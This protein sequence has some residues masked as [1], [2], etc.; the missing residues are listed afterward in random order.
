MRLTFLGTGAALPSRTRN[1][2]ALALSFE[3]RGGWWLFDCG[4]GTQHRILASPLSPARLERV[5]LSHLHGDHCFGLPGLLCSR[6]MHGQA[7]PIAIHGPRGTGDYLAAIERTTLTHFGFRIELG[8]VDPP[9]SFPTDD[10]ITVHAAEVVHAKTTL[11]WV[12]CEADFAGRLRADELSAMGVPSGP[13][14]GALKRGERVSLPD[15]RVIDGALYTDPPRPG[16][17]LAIVFDS[18][19][20]GAIVERARGADVLVHEAT[21]LGRTDGA[22][23]RKNHHSTA[24]DAGALAA[25][26]EARVLVLNHLSPRYDAPGPGEPGVADLV[27]E[28]RMQFGGEVVCAYDGYV[29]DVPRRDPVPRAHPPSRSAMPGSQ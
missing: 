9:S 1:V 15:G 24:A 10:G 21:Y 6:W 13:L 4:E 8:E 29:L 23:A 5:F 27:A 22:L 11:A 20:S 7:G 2:S 28:A 12:V 3:Q 25:R 16:R 14:L 26:I 18:C 17:R 19:D